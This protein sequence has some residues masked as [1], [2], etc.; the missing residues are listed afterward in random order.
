MDVCV[1]LFVF[2]HTVLYRM[3]HVPGVIKKILPLACSTVQYCTQ[4]FSCSAKQIIAFYQK[5]ILSRLSR[6]ISRFEV[7]NVMFHTPLAI[8]R[9]VRARG[10]H[11]HEPSYMLYTCIYIICIA[12]YW[13]GLRSMVGLRALFYR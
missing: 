8:S 6:V 13:V 7:I 4:K 5:T 9:S 12:I 3:L 2:G 11:I 1:C 10:S